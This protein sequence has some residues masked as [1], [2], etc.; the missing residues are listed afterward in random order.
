MHVCSA[1]FEDHL[2]GGNAKITLISHRYDHPI[3]RDG[4]CWSEANAIK[5]LLGSSASQL[6]KSIPINEHSMDSIRIMMN[7]TNLNSDLVANSSEMRRLAKRS[8]AGEKSTKLDEYLNQNKINHQLNSKANTGDN[9][10][11]VFFVTLFL[12]M[13]SMMPTVLTFPTE[14]RILQEELKNG[15]YGCSSYYLAKVIADTPFII[16]NAILFCSI[17]YPLTGQLLEPKIF[18]LFTF[19]A[20]IVALIAHCIGMLFG[21]IYVHSVASATFMAPLSM[22]PV[23]LLSGFFARISSL[24]LFLKPIAYV[25]YVRYCFGEIRDS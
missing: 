4:S 22:S 16:F 3:G 14:V 20:L 23:F 10:A 21:T 19:V 18:Y 25:S 6:A 12:V 11:F 1:P 9:I 24:P 15:Y 13:S 7:L 17:V 5:E 8:V 2:V